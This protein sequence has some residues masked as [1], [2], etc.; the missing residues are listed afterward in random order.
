[1]AV[2]SSKRESEIQ[3]SVRALFEQYQRFVGDLCGEEVGPRAVVPVNT[4]LIASKL[5]HLPTRIES[6]IAGGRGLV[7]AGRYDGTE[8]L[9]ADD[10]EMKRTRYTEAHEIGHHRLHP[11]ETHFYQ[12]SNGV[13]LLAPVKE[14]EA[15]RFAVNLLMPHELVIDEF[16]SRFG[17]V[18][19][20][21]TVD[22]TVA[23]ALTHDRL[24][25]SQVRQ[26]PLK[27]FARLIVRSRWFH[28]RQFD[29]MED[30]F[31]VSGETMAIR[32]IELGLVS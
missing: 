14:Q 11:G 28:G 3:S 13:R 26:M 19:S 12:R 21:Q 9:L 10:R 24:T 30:V 17:P 7:T 2:L 8:I 4:R 32:V 23:Y 25:P 18:L 20:K 22:E 29:A 15:N 27:D 1:M 16:T 5:L 6:E 31:G